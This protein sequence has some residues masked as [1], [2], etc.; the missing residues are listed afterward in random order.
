MATGNSSRQLYPMELCATKGLVCVPGSFQVN[1]TSDPDNARGDGFTVTYSAVGEYLITLSE[2][3][4]MLVSASVL[5]QDTDAD[6][7]LDLA[8]V[9]ED[10]DS[11]AGTIIVRVAQ[12]DHLDAS[13]AHNAADIDNLRVNFVLYF[14]KY[15]ALSVTHA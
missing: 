8:C 3:Y 12:D 14:Q 15:T 1:S 11:S 4:P 2:K 7:D 10:Y 5:L 6:N 13:S 9:I